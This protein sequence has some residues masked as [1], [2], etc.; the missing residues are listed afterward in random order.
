MDIEDAAE[1]DQLL[2]EDEEEEEADGEGS[3]SFNSEEIID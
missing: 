2:D 1:E 3:E